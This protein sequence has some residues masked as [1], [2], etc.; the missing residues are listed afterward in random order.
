MLIDI[1]S[2]RQAAKNK[3]ATTGD[4]ATL[5]TTATNQPQNRDFVATVAAVATSPRV[6]AASL[7]PAPAQ[8]VATVATVA[9][10]ATS[11]VV[12]PAPSMAPLL[13]LAD[14]YCTAIGASDKAQQDWRADI[15]ATPPDDRQ[16]L[17]AYLRGELAKLVPPVAPKPAPPAVVSP[18]AT[19]SPAKP[20]PKFSVH[21]P[22]NEADRAYQAHHWN[23][24]TCKA[25]ARS[26]HSDRCVQ[27]QQLHSAYEQ[28][29]EAAKGATP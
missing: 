9:A 24:T 10:V 6:E 23:C 28:A 29:F 15:E 20:L 16:G 3:A 1:Q 22:W 5:A 17:A 21:Q 26:G 13:A 25:A 4:V 14:R 12:Q 11:P 19:P 27:G 8:S 18:A 7:L 2:I